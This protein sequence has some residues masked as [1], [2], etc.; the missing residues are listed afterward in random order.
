MWRTLKADRLQPLERTRLPPSRRK[1]NGSLQGD[2]LGVRYH[3][4]DSQVRF[5][6]SLFYTAQ[7]HKL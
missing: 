7:Y 2:V 4:S 3:R 6:F 5:Q 1:T